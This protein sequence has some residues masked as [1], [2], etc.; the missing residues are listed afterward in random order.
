[1][2]KQW[3]PYFFVSN[4]FDRSSVA[5]LNYGTILFFLGLLFYP[6]QA[7]IIP[8]ELPVWLIQPASSFL[9]FSMGLLSILYLKSLKAAYTTS[10]VSISI[11][12]GIIYLLMYFS[13]GSFMGS[14]G[15]NP[16]GTT[17]IA[18]VVN[19]I[20]AIS[21]GFGSESFRTVLLVHSK[22]K[23]LLI[24]LTSLMFTAVMIP[25]MS[26][27][28]NLM[29]ENAVKMLGSKFPVLIVFLLSGIFN[30]MGGINSGVAFLTTVMLGETLLPVLP[31]LNWIE[32]SFTALIAIITVYMV[33]SRSFPLS[34]D[35]EGSDYGKL[36][37][38]LVFISMIWLSNGLLGYQVV[39]VTSGSMRPNVDVG[40]L[41]VV[42][43]SSN[44]YSNGDIILYKLNN[45]YVLHRI[46]DISIV[47]GTKVI[48]TKGDANDGV[49]PWEVASN[50]VVGLMVFKIPKL[51][52]L[53]LWFKQLASKLT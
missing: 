5:R 47:K 9:W 20:W 24:G 7:F 19:T 39:V 18:I 40:D 23:A 36:I 12:S 38:G 44:D 15:R 4:F 49:D 1:M 14:I 3:T 29:A 22:R 48:H 16:L 25:L 42:K 53:T 50:Q 45:G 11:V 46:H 30:Y 35:M 2:K 51:G 26:I 10:Y 28:N 31:N 8:Q 21:I 41:A 43:L 17:P 27:P 37:L 13:I 6:L 32:A 33:A 52:W 34:S